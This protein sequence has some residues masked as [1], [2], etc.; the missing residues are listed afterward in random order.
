MPA[1]NKTQRRSQRA[2]LALIAGA[3]ATTAAAVLVG[4]AF[5]RDMRRA[6]ARVGG[7]S[8]IIAS[9]FGAIEYA[10]VGQG[11][12]LM[13]IHGTGGGF[14]QSL[15][16]S[17]R[18][19]AAGRRIIAPSRFGYLLSDLPDDPSSARQADAFAVLLD[20]LGIDRIPVAG[21]SA[22]ALSAAAFAIRH[23]DRC[24]CLVLL[25]PAAN[26]L[27]K[28]P[29]VLAAWQKA[30]LNDVLGSDFLFWSARRLAPE[31]L[32]GLILATDPALLQHVSADERSRAIGLLTDIMP[33]SLRTRGMLN[34]ALRAGQPDGTDYS[35]ITT[36]MLV[37]STEDDRFGTAETARAI[38]AMQPQARLV[39]YPSG[40]HIWLG[41]DADVADE[42]LRFT[43]SL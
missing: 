13:M 42:I 36:P 37:L 30:L 39:I 19:I 29:V 38:A 3:V 32:I 17:A 25:V 22:G 12:P 35:A 1:D 27:G 7:R 10:D 23:P 41:H 15:R 16:F 40:G 43:E 6:R 20:H 18:L 5:R 14:D 28:D 26:V 9:R 34:D 24:A 11:P 8:Q 4:R 21:G 33:V 2:A 31:T